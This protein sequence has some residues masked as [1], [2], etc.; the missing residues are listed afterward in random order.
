MTDHLATLS[1]RGRVTIPKA[2]RD[3]LG[4]R[5]NDKIRFINDDGEV[6]LERAYPSLEEVAASLPALDW[7]ISVED[8][9][10]LA[11]EER[12]RELAAKLRTV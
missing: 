11:H 3:E 7:D 6:R 10:A 5:P 2:I 4:L 12:A 8:A 9:I 1:T